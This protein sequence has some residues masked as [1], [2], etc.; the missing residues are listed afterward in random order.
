MSNSRGKSVRLTVA[1]AIITYLAKQYS[2]ADGERR[3]LVPAT[4]G[5]FGHGNV[6]GMGQALDQL[7]DLMPFVQGRNEQS[8]GHLSTG[9][10][11]AMK[12]RAT[13]AVT[14]SIG[15]GALNLWISSSKGSR[16]GGTTAVRGGRSPDRIR[17]ALLTA[18]EALGARRIKVNPDGDDAPWNP[19]HWAAK[20][21]ELAARYTRPA[22]RHLGGQ[23]A[24]SR[25]RPRN[26]GRGGSASSSSRGRTSRRCSTA[27][28]SSKPPATTGR[29][30]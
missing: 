28:G 13:L 30:S 3:R 26:V 5:I 10:G 16:T 14:A 19:D 1:Q 8:L 27:C 24:R 11:K 25:P 15:P 6:A 9:Y 18:A 22:P 17:H 20:L 2:V 4:L 29:A 12:R 21:A 7:S 23:L